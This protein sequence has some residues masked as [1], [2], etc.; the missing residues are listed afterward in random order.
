MIIVEDREAIP[1]RATRRLPM[2]ARKVIA[3]LEEILGAILGAILGG[4][5]G[6][7]SLSAFGEGWSIVGTV[8]GISF[9]AV[10]GWV[11]ALIDQWIRDSLF[12]R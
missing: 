6:Y 3:L 10:V 4:I 9:G 1:T 5:I 11:I 8:V 2:N 7:G 12:R